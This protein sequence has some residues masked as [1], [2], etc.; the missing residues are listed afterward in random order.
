MD[1]TFHPS[2]FLDAKVSLFENVYSLIPM[3]TITLRQ[4][5]FNKNETLISKVDKI[6]TEGNDDLKPTLP[7][8]TG[9]GV[10]IGDREDQNL[11]NHNGFIIIDID[12]KHNIHLKDDFFEL[13]EKVFNDLKEIC[14]AGLSVRG[15]GYY[16]I[17]RIENPKRHKEYFEYLSNWF[18]DAE[19]INIDTS[20]RNI[21]RLRIFSVDDNPYI[22]EKAVALKE[23]ILGQNEKYSV[24]K[25][26]YS[27]KNDLTELVEKIEASGIS[28]A[29]S[30]DEYM[31]LAIVFHSE[32]GEN[33]RGLY[34]RVCSLDSKYDL[35]DCDIQF[36][37]VS[38]R[39]YTRCTKGTL[40]YLMKEY[41]VI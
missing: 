5:I 6:R 31:K 21:S 25:S 13:K 32:Q 22:N 29:P 15:K 17:I 39:D 30:Y 20:T 38:K 18:K 10:I 19:D 40:L 41:N 37:K 28:I 7:C 3:K 16:L 35:K 2:T 24:S 23:S 26:I 34:H 33:G 1:F 36:D 8:I 4:W 11:K 27:S 12:H 14:Y 9:S